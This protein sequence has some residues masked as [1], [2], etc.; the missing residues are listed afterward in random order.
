M[1]TK[2]LAICALICFLNGC[3]TVVDVTVYTDPPFATLY[4][5][6]GGQN[7]GTSPFK[8]R[9]S[10]SEEEAKLGYKTFDGVEARW[11][12]GATASVPQITV[13]LN[14]GSAQNITIRRPESPGREIDLQY[15]DQK[16]REAISLYTAILK[17]QAENDKIRA[18][19]A[20]T[21]AIQ[22]AEE[23]RRFQNRSYNCTSTQ[24]GNNVYT[25]CQ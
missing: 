17:Q 8:S 11:R 14:Q 24:S 13:R 10:F 21:K 15:A 18:Y 22:E 3:A 25:N 4:T 16:R 1:I 5:L 19:E 2:F 20:R 7:I 6:R 23:Q 9:V 12:S